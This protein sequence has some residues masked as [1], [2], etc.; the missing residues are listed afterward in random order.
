M[1]NGGKN[2]A[3]SVL[4]DHVT[5]VYD[6]WVLSVSYLTVSQ[7]WRRSQEIPKWAGG[8]VGEGAWGG[9]GGG[10]GAGCKSFQFLRVPPSYILNNVNII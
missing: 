3:Q 10:G 9:G 1:A 8:G 7:S 4:D 5:H 2:S 6:A